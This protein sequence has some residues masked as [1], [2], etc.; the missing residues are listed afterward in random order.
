ERLVSGYALREG[1]DPFG[2]SLAEYSAF[3]NG[4]AS[5]ESIGVARTQSSSL[6]AGGDTVRV[7]G[8]VVTSDYLSTAGV[9]PALGRVISPVADRPGSSA[10]VVISH[11]LW[12]RQFAGLPGTV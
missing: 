11:S 12:I 6:R 8:A 7:Q 2:T 4:V 1:F 3:K 9:L 10:V 5:F